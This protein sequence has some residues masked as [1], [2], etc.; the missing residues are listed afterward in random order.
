MRSSVKPFKSPIRGKSISLCKS[1]I[2][3]CKKSPKP[4]TTVKKR[5]T[6]T[7]TPRPKSLNQSIDFS[8]NNSKMFSKATLGKPKFCPEAI[9]SPIFDVNVCRE[10]ISR[11]Q[12]QVK[13]ESLLESKIMRDDWRRAKKSMEVRTLN[14]IRNH[15][16]FNTNQQLVFGQ[17]M[18]NKFRQARL[19]E[20]QRKEEEYLAC[21]EVKLKQEL[22][23]KQKNND[24]LQRNRSRSLQKQEIRREKSEALRNEKNVERESFF[25]FVDVVKQRDYEDKKREELERKF[26]YASSLSGSWLKLNKKS[27][28]V[29][30]N[31]N[32]IG[33]LINK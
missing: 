30:E 13:G 29:K 10:E 11:L 9:P 27:Q 31:I 12:S 5:S 25:D 18:E 32:I 17:F 19:E 8:L 21:K 23:E 22:N 33:K 24:D 4:Q 14:E 20:R 15:S 1:P 16:N 26:E 6:G 3:H 7:P 28:E 2:S